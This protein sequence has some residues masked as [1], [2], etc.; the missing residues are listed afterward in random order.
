MKVFL[1]GFGF[2]F[3]LLTHIVTADEAQIPAD[4]VEPHAWANVQK[5]ASADALEAGRS[6]PRE[7]GQHFYRK[8]VNFLFDTSKLRP[9]GDGDTLTRT[10]HLH[11]TPKL[12]ER[13]QEAET[14]RDI[15][16][17]VFEVIEM[18]REGRLEQVKEIVISVTDIITNYLN[19]IYNSDTL[20]FLSLA[21]ATVGFV[22]I[23]SRRLQRNIVLVFILTIVAISYFLMYLDC[24]QKLE[25]EKLMELNR[26]AGKNPC[27]VKQSFFSWGTHSEDDCM[28]HLKNSYG[29]QRSICRPTEVLLQF[30]SH[31]TM[32]QFVTFIQES[33]ETF[34][35]I[36]RKY[37]WKEQIVILPFVL[38]FTY[39]MM[40]ILIK[41]TFKYVVP[42]IMGSINSHGD[43]QSAPQQFAQRPP[44]ADQ[45]ILSGESVQKLLNLLRQNS[46]VTLQQA[47]G[48]LETEGGDRVQVLPPTECP[49]EALE[50]SGREEQE[51][52][53]KENE[54]NE[55]EQNNKEKS[56]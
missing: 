21:V 41:Y 34:S 52:E 38:Y 35:G 15:D 12:L 7:E 6:I 1:Y 33:H 4:W 18:S 20:L 51:E 42:A 53:A 39:L 2:L 29:P 28:K 25:I 56:T 40:S 19:E 10:L 14:A 26:M 49:P 11:I 13:L 27:H 16:S 45:L 36:F 24:N 43:G 47:A 32:T 3:I 17:V 37:T 9:N 55:I 8:L 44:E 50:P 30:F 23:V 46:T 22:W 31:L 54:A 48:A 5:R